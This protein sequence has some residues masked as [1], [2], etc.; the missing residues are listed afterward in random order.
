M[1]MDQEIKAEWLEALRSGEYEQG[2]GVLRTGD[3]K[4]CCL[5]VLCEVLVKRGLMEAPKLDRGENMY[6]YQEYSAVLPD[7]VQVRVGLPYISDLMELNDTKGLPFAEIA[8]YIEE[9]K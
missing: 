6:D 2:I 7:P 9:N 5:G 8:N 3:D 4:F 1:G